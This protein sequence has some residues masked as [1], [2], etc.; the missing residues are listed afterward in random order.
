MNDLDA[1]TGDGD[2]GSTVKLG[3]Q[4]VLK[5]VANSEART[6]SEL[7]FDIALIL[8]EE[9][10]GSSGSLLSI[11]FTAIAAQIKLADESSSF[12]TISKS[13]KSG[14]NEMMLVG[15]AQPGD[16][17][18]L[19]ALIPAQAAIESNA[20][21]PTL[22]LKCAAE[23]AEKG[24]KLTAT[25][26]AKAGRAAYCKDRNQEKSPDAG[27]VMVAKVFSAIYSF[28]NST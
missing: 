8:E 18:M 15:R 6:Y 14:I 10:G 17:T 16:R 9:M 24:S 7:I 25:M 28:S 22:A 26:K 4:A 3:A 19:D 23:A 21:D 5:V 13:L 1:L 27:A 20:D 11:L 2:C 12:L